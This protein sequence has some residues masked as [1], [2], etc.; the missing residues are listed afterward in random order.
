MRYVFLQAGLPA[1]EA[2]EDADAAAEA[3]AGEEPGSPHVII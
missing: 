3:A 2:A 1:V